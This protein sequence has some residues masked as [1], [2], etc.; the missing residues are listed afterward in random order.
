[1][2]FI[3]VTGYV[4]KVL[5]PR[6]EVRINAMVEE[7]SKNVFVEIDGVKKNL[8]YLMIENFMPDVKMNQQFR[9]SIKNGNE[10]P[11]QVIRVTDF[12][13][14]I[15]SLHE[16]TIHKYK[17]KQR[18]EAANVRGE[19]IITPLHVAECLIN[20]NFKCLYCNDHLDI[21]NWHLDH[22]IPLAKG[23][24]NR[25][26]NIVPSCY[27]CNLMKGAFSPAKF[28]KQILKIAS[29]FKYNK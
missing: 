10:I 26:D 28:E 15:S 3:H 8:L 12:V 22:F 6:K 4:V 11:L 18:A 19:G 9:Y 14:S 20:N 24:T 29:H 23:G 2:Y 16:E 1:M 5:G 27:M 7:N 21:R 17:C 13:S 25:F